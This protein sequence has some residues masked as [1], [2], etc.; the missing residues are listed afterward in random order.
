MT[1]ERKQTL[2]KLQAVA[3]PAVRKFKEAERILEEVVK[4]GE[5]NNMHINQDTGKVTDMQDNQ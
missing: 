5:I 4:L 2:L 3:I 1:K